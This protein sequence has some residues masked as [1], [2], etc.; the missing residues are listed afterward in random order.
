MKRK[1]L[2]RGGVWRGVDSVGVTR[3]PTRGLMADVGACAYSGSWGEYAIE[4]THASSISTVTDEA[5]RI[6][7]RGEADEE[8]LVLV[9]RRA[10]RLGRDG[11]QTS[12]YG[13]LQRA[14]VPPERKKTQEGH[15]LSC[16]YTICGGVADLKFGHYIRPVHDGQRIRGIWLGKA[17]IIARKWRGV[18]GSEVTWRERNRHRRN[19]RG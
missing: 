1:E 18:A 12:V 11:R 6:R 8:A 9:R 5:Q 15:D 14:C 2:G 10:S 4:G 17:V 19:G 7:A 3:W 13:R 16:P